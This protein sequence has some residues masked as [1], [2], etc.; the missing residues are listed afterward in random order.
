MEA[1]KAFGPALRLMKLLAGV[2]EINILPLEWSL[3]YTVQGS[4]WFFYGEQKNKVALVARSDI[5]TLLTHYTLADFYYK[6][7]YMVNSIPTTACHISPGTTI[8]IDAVSRARRLWH[9][10]VLQLFKGRLKRVAFFNFASFNELILK[11]CCPSGHWQ[12]YHH[13]SL[14]LLLIKSSWVRATFFF[15]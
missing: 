1:K 11:K 13:F 12:N 2:K 9:T 7:F 3:N 4:Q 14:L 15:T 10:V 6:N 5:L 8:K